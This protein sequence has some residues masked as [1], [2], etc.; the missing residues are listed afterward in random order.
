MSHRSARRRLGLVAATATAALGMAGAAQAAIVIKVQGPGGAPLP[1]ERVT[2]TGANGQRVYVSGAGTTDATG[3]TSF[4]LDRYSPAG[5]YTAA[6]SVSGGYAC[7]VT[8]DQPASQAG[9]VDGTTTTL[10]VTVPLLCPGLT[11]DGAAAPTGLF[12]QAAQTVLAIPGGTA[13]V[14]PRVPYD[15]TGIT[16]TAPGA[17]P[18]APVAKSSDPVAVT[19]PA[20]GY[21]GPLTVSYTYN[22]VPVSYAAGAM[23]SRPVAATAPTPGPIDIELIVDLSASMGGT[24]PK[25]VRRDALSLLVD[26]MRPGDRLGATGFSTESTPIFPLTEITGTAGDNAL[27]AAGRRGIKNAGGTDYNLGMNDANTALTTTPGVDLARQKAVVFLTDGA[28]GNEYLNGHLRFALNAS[29]RAWP[30]CPIQLGAPRSFQKKDVDLLKRIASETG[31]RYFATAGAGRLSDIYSQCFNLV[32]AQRT[33]A[34]RSFGFA[35]RATKRMTAKAPRGLKQATFFASWGDGAY[36]LV[37]VDP[38]G[39]RIAPARPG[40]GVAYRHGSTFAFYRV[41]NPRAGTWRLELRNLRLTQGRDTG[42]L[43]VMTPR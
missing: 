17:A 35:P 22:G 5:P 6:V 20:A 43:S 40:K 1:G 25:Y 27:K 24:D 41:T 42:K 18:A 9:V 10:A 34:T 14:R 31:G 30:V 39:R 13:Y 36:R 28:N 15:A 38:R 16:V 12:D 23:V 11:P 37:L 2:L 21:T 7:G 3:T 29:G 33:I 4:T 32:A 26:L 19:A 8:P